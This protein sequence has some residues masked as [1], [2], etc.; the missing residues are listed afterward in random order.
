MTME[1]NTPSRHV[2]TRNV[3]VIASSG[4]IVGLACAAAY[5]SVASTNKGNGIAAWVAVAIVGA[6]SVI[7]RNRAY[8]QIQAT[9]PKENQR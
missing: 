2:R 5:T 1:V 6:S 7:A 8:E 3:S 9:K 4:M